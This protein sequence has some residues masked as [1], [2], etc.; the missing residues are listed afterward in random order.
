[1]T[2]AQI[3]S[4]IRRTAAAN[5][6]APLGMDRFFSETGVKQGDWRGKYWVRWGD[7]L[8]EAGFAPNDLQAARSDDD[9]LTCLAGLVRELGHFPVVAEIKLKA[10]SDPGFPWHNTFSRLGRKGILAA[11]LKRFCEEKGDLEVAKVCAQVAKPEA[12]VA[13]ESTGIAPVGYV[14]LVRHG[15]RHEYKIG[16]TNNPMRREGE[17]RTE[18]PEQLSPIHRITTDDPAGIERYWHMRFADK[19]KNGEWF[20]LDANDVRAF[21]RWRDIY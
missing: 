16:R 21:K 3:L 9:L 11:R 8:Q 18:L 2:K 5:G 10:R 4:E 15:S 20:A 17:I 7:A 1:M 13:D 19:R 14:Y 6:G 12:A